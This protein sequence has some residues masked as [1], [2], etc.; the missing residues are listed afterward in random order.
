MLLRL[1]S[2]F[3]K[4]KWLLCRNVWIKHKQVYVQREFLWGSLMHKLPTGSLLGT[5]HRPPTVLFPPHKFAKGIWCTS[6]IAFVPAIALTQSRDWA[7][8]VAQS[9][10]SHIRKLSFMEGSL[11]ICWTASSLLRRWQNSANLYYCKDSQR[12][13]HSISIAWKQSEMDPSQ[14]S[15]KHTETRQCAIPRVMLT[16]LEFNVRSSGHP[17]A[18]GIAESTAFRQLSLLEKSLSVGKGCEPLSR[19]HPQSPRW[20]TTWLPRVPPSWELCFKQRFKLCEVI[21]CFKIVFSD[22]C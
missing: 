1:F 4:V 12:V 10:G 16:K 19:I 21:V 22:L 3:K 18:S 2:Y 20:I 7:V 11:H 15:L 5:Y 17:E 14:A 13:I 8:A 9:G 6:S